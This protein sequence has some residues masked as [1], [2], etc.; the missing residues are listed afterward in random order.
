MGWHNYIGHRL[1]NDFVDTD[2]AEQ[3]FNEEDDDE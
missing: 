1:T 2:D 3:D